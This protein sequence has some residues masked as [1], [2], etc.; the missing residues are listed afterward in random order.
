MSLES[1]DEQHKQ[2]F[3]VWH[4]DRSWSWNKTVPYSA[5]KKKNIDTYQ[6][7]RFEVFEDGVLSDWQVEL[8]ATEDE[9]MVDGVSHQVD[10]GSHDKSD[11]A[12]VDRWARQRPGTALNQLNGTATHI[13]CIFEQLYLKRS[14]PLLLF[15]Y[16]RYSFRN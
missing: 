16:F 9:T 8:V 12:E 11:D 2:I 13:F 15:N 4:Y 3:V 7:G 6:W 14:Y 10:A 1:H 5:L